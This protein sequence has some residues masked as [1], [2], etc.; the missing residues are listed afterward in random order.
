MDSQQQLAALVQCLMQTLDPVHRIQAEKQL[1]EG[2]KTPGFSILLLQLID[3]TTV[4]PSVRFAAALYFK[5]FVKKEWIQHDDDQDKISYEDRST[6]KTTIISLMV[7]VPLSLRNSLSDAVT[8]IADCDFPDKWSN[9]LP[10]LVA[11][12]SLQN[13]DGNV[14]VLQTAHSIFKRWRHHFR[15]DALYSEIK[16]SINQF[17]S[18]YFEFFKA[19]DAM[20]DS[21]KDD[22]P[23]IEKLLEILLFLI[24][25]F[26]SLNCHDLPEFFE[27][28]HAHFMNL[29]AKYLSYQNPIVSSDSD[30]AGPIEK[31]KSMTCEVIDLYARLYEDDFPRLPEF[32]Q[33]IWMHLIETSESPKNDIL[34]NRMMSFLASVAKPAHHR[35]FFE[36]PGALERICGQIVLPNMALR[37]ADEELF[38]DDAIEYIRRDL[39]GS[40]S[41]SRRSAAVELVRGLLEH[42]SVEIT[43]IFSVYIS[44]YLENYESDRVANWHAK[45]TALFLITALSARSVTAQIGVTQTNEHI[46]ILPVF[47]AH[48]LPDLHAAIDGAMHPIIKVDAI[49]YLTIFRSQNNCLTL[50]PHVVNHLSS[51]NYVVHTWAAHAI[52]RILSLKSGNTLMFSPADTATFAGRVLSHLFDRIEAGG[53]PEKLSENDYLMKC[54]MRVIA[55]VRDQLPDIQSV[56]S[57][58]VTIINEISKNPSNPKFNH[59]VFESVA[60]MIRFVSASNPAIVSDFE[61][62][63]IQPFLSILQLD[64]PEFSPYV[65]QIFAQLISLRPGAGLSPA[66]QSLLTPLLTPA[67]WQSLGNVPALVVLLQAYIRKG[68][69][70]LFVHSQLAAFFGVCQTL[71]KS[72]HT[73][74]QGFSLLITIFENFFHVATLTPFMKTIFVVILTRL[75]QGKASRFPVNFL[76][77]ICSL[78]VLDKSDLSVDIVIDILDSIQPTPL[79]GGLLQ[80][81][82]IPNF[83]DLQNTS[84]R[85][86]CAIA[87]TRLLFQGDCM[88]SD[89]YVS[90]WPTLL[91][92]VTDLAESANSIKVSVSA[93]PN[94]ATGNTQTDED[95]DVLSSMDFAEDA[96]YQ[97]SFVRLSTLEKSTVATLVDGAADP[98][99]YLIQNISKYT[100][101]ADGGAMVSAKE[102]ARRA[103]IQQL[104]SMPAVQQDVMPRL[105]KF[106]NTA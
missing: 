62:F 11:R 12:L 5:N 55:T 87:M 98:A 33:T 94:G 82:L 36:Q 46:P 41:D 45:D 78:L 25:I 19:I 18:P 101:A 17:A 99:I 2:E 27:D 58:L 72:R 28:H 1:A 6:I 43:Q 57:R 104:M 106:T 49:K 95:P 71:L 52:E 40:V 10:D 31:I 59:F 84:D 75:S 102:G 66:Y 103:K 3:S 61:S 90:L 37:A 38:E 74:Q 15:S 88:L 4:D 96:G 32:V 63:L 22:K 93:D 67:L 53:T 8:I 13:L 79:F 92:A 89:A 69:A 56:L 34:V 77:F 76:R 9:L 16:F 51:K 14:G 91:I 83:K 60:L 81:I 24:K 20:I 47:L 80:S 7:T 85:K 26:Y 21:S 35:F 42:F 48:V 44:K 23:R 50:C 64:V 54:V 29:F 97:V 39:E 65:F 70:D 73:D 105:S 100:H 30:E 86:Q 68:H